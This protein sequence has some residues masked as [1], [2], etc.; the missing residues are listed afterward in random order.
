MV[1]EKITDRR[2]K[3]HPKSVHIKKNN[4]KLSRESFIFFTIIL[5]IKPI[6]GTN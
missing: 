6:V 4:K 2:S 1:P 3:L 5:N